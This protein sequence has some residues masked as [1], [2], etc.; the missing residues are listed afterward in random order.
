MY[1]DSQYLAAELADNL[2]CYP[3]MEYL[4][5]TDMHILWFSDNEIAYW[6]RGCPYFLPCT[7]KTTVGKMAGKD[8][9]DMQHHL[10]EM[11]ADHVP[12]RHQRL[13]EKER[14]QTL[15][16]LAD[17]HRLKQCCGFGMIIPDPDFYLSRISDPGSKN[18]NKREG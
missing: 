14:N 6:A 2:S 8:V 5:K 7:A 15:I 17:F 11:Q 13:A 9:A 1:L 12:E 16:I 10:A 18:S 3:V 4:F